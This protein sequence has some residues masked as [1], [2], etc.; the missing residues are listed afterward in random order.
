MHLSLFLRII[1]PA[2]GLIPF[3]LVVVVVVLQSVI[4]MSLQVFAAGRP[5][6]PIHLGGLSGGYT[7]IIDT[8]E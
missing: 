5:N 6:V 8:L 2:L 7:Y 1:S 3:Y 4:I